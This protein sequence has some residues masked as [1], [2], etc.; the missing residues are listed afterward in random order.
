MSDSPDTGPSGGDP[1]PS[2]SSLR[3]RVS[4][5]MAWALAGRAV[6]T[7]SGIVLAGLATRLLSTSDAGT[8]FLALSI[9]TSAAAIGELGLN[10]AAVRLVAEALAKGQPGR[11]RAAIRH[12]WRLGL[13]AAALVALVVVSPAGSWFASNVFDT[14]RLDDVLFLVSGF[15]IL[16]VLGQLRAEIFRGFKDIRLASLFAGVDANV[17]AVI[18]LG[19][20]FLLAPAAATLTIVL[21][22]VVAAW[23]PGI[24]LG[25]WLLR[26]RMRTL[27]GPGNVSGRTVFSIA[28]PMLVVGIGSLLLAHADLW[29]VGSTQPAE[30]TAVYGAVLR[31]V[32]LISVPIVIVNGAVPPFIAE[33][34]TKGHLRQMEQM[35]RV[36]SALAFIPTALVFVVF[37]L[38]GGGVLEF[39]FGADYARGWM[40]LILLSVGG[41]VN[42]W[43]GSN[44]Y[45]LHMTGRE[46]TAMI[47][48]TLSALGMIG[49]A[50]VAAGPLDLGIRG[51]AGVAATGIVVRN[52]ALWL[53]ARRLVGVWTHVGIIPVFHALHQWRLGRHDPEPSPSTD[54]S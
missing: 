5:G 43:V 3:R 19:L 54:G 29:I 24:A 47:V 53:I 22:M 37:L 52:V 16:R 18:L 46:R 38:F 49:G 21:G 15:I 34:Y 39:L 35:L 17:V 7:V 14:S 1:P 6:F 32:G 25:Y 9:G 41:A 4:T 12:V 23:I 10:R 30:D 44:A 2:P 8:F 45:L 33:L 42:V 40:V 20:L 27:V 28:W 13:T 31:L 26:R 50:V 48:T 51:V 11:A 36:S